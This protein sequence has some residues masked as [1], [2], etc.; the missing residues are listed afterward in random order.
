MLCSQVKDISKRKDSPNLASEDRT[1]GKESPRKSAV[2]AHVNP[3]KILD[4]VLNTKVELAVE[5]YG[6]S[7][8]LSTLLAD[9]I[10]LERNRQ[11]P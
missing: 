11:H 2:S 5:K 10:K 4:H 7:R 6:V 1:I 8:E 3:F 9:S